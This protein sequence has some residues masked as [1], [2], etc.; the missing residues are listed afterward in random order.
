MAGGDVQTFAFVF[1]MNRLFEQFTAVTVIRHLSDAWAPLGWTPRVQGARRTLLRDEACRDR[2]WLC[3]DP[4]MEDAAGR[5]ALVPDTKY[6]R[7]DLSDPQA[8][9]AEADAYQ[10]FAYAR[11]YDCPRIVLLYP[12]TADD[13]GH[14]AP[15]PVRRFGTA[16]DAVPWLEVKLARQPPPIRPRD[17]LR[18]PSHRRGRPD[19]TR[20]PPGTRPP[21]CSRRRS[22]PGR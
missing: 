16:G 17:P 13:V 3:P 6:K 5:A 8:G 7:P 4:V 12:R 11:R 15:P 10:M 1:G 2:F 9:V 20:T 21:G 14:D 19:R 22:S 18:P